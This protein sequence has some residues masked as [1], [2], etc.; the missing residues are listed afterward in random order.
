MKVA[1]LASAFALA[2]TGMAEAQMI[3]PANPLGVV[4]K[5]QE[6]GYRAQ[7]DPYESGRPRIR[8]T[9]EGTNYSLAFYNCRSDFTSCGSMLLSAGFDMENGTTFDI[10]NGWNGEKILG[11]AY[12]GRENDPWIDFF[13]DAE[14]GIP[15]ATF[16]DAI[17]GWGRTLNEFKDKIGWN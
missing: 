15:D 8:S 12:L 4:Q 13:I 11:R 1:A 9:I 2:L 6:M 16:E 3:D 5:L 10:V 17:E 7:V 14:G